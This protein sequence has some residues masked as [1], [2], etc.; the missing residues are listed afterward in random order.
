MLRNE[1]VKVLTAVQPIELQNSVRAQ[2]NG[3]LTTPD[4][5][6]NSQTP[7][8]AALRLEIENWRWKGVPF[9]LRSGKA[10]FQD[11]TPNMLSISIQPDEGIHFCFDAKVPDQAQQTRAVEM[12]FHYSDSF[13]NIDLP[14]AYERL[15]LDALNGDASLFARIDEIENAWGIIDPVIAGWNR[16][17]APP[18][19]SYKTGS[20]GPK[21]ADMLLASEG[22][23]WHMD[24]AHE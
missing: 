3:Y 7:T 21:A 17:D 8:Y 19:Q 20:W 12:D 15:L 16:P 10:A 11:P 9:Y 24:E 5:A 6:P 2:Y 18:M 4:V 1:K 14:D 13:E 23:V 22:Y